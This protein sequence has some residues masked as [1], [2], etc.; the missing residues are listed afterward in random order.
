MFDVYIQQS[1]LMVLIVS[2]IP[3]VASSLVALVVSVLQAATQVQE[4]TITYLSKFLIVC[5]V[6]V[7]L[8]KWFGEEILK[9]SEE[10]LGSLALFGRL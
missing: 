3:L 8:S 7:F 1:F 9:F 5:F 2:G 6:F 10:T 4:Q